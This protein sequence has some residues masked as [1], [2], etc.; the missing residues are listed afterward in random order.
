LRGRDYDVGYVGVNGDG[1]FGRVNLSASG[2]FAFGRDRNSIFTGAPAN[3]RA[4]F[5]AAEPSYDFSWIR[6]R[7]SALYASGDRDP[8]DKTETGYDAILEN[9]IFAGA[10]TSYWIRQSIPFV[11]GARAVGINGRNGVLADLRSS[12]DQGQSNFNNPGTLLLGAGADADITPTLRLSA[13]AN[14][15]SFVTTAPLQALRN[16]GSIPKSIGWDLSASAIWRP[17]ATQ[18]LVFRLSG[19]VLAAGKGFRDLFTQSNGSGRFYSVLANA[20]LSF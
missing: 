3:I 17:R 8:Y 14:H 11:G 20:V 10:D 4:F 2:Y 15:L 7:A 13:N 19:A 1:H 18:N 16:E 9:P 12:K 5:A 6:V